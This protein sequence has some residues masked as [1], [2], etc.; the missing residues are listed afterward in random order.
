MPN[1]E[2][3]VTDDARPVW[4]FKIDMKKARFLVGNNGIDRIVRRGK[5]ISEDQ[6][7]EWVELVKR[8]GTNITIRAA[9]AK[10]M[11]L[12]VNI[13]LSGGLARISPN[14]EGKVREAL[15]A[16]D[17]WDA[18]H[19]HELSEYDRLYRRFNGIPPQRLVKHA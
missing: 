8:D 15:E 13:G 2:D 6:R 17:N 12:W 5:M 19:D 16:I 18:A 4:P 7:T 9:E 1:T 11:G 3:A 14:L 10:E